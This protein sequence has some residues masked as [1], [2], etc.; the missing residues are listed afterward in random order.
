MYKRS[1]TYSD[2]YKAY[3][4]VIQT[5]RHQMVGK[6]SRQTNH[7]E[8]W[9]NTLRQRICRF[10]RK[11]LSFSKCDEMH[12]LYLKLFVYNYN[13]KCANKITH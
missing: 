8:R 2:Y 5:G 13:M 7:I 12:E 1:L 10:V 4:N 11:T 3:E 6:E 9:N